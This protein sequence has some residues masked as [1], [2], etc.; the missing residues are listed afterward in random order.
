MPEFYEVQRIREYL[1]DAGILNNPITDV[2]VM[3]LGVRLLA[4]TSPAGFVALLRDNQIRKIHQRAKYSIFEMAKG[5]FVC[6]YRFTAIPFVTGFPYGDRLQ[7][8][9]NLPVAESRTDRIRI[10]INF[11]HPERELLYFDTRRLS[12]IR[13]YPDARAIDEISELSVLADDLEHFQPETFLEFQKRKL[14]L[15]AYLQDQTVPPSGVGN[16]L[17][18]EILARATLFPWKECRYLNVKEYER[19]IAAIDE[20]KRLAKENTSYDWFWVYNRDVCQVCGEKVLREKR[21]HSQSTYFCNPC[22]IK[23]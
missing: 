7:V 22:I 15:K 17:A 23:Q 19:L 20:V 8:I 14:H 1:S 12:T 2:G 9:H 11:Q 3:P 21:G 5:F 18:C 16:Y 6:H 4:N 13:I 10:R